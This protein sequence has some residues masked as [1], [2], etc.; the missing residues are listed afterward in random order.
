METTKPTNR[1]TC[2]IQT[3]PDP[4]QLL[5]TSYAEVNGT[6]EVRCET[7]NYPFF[8]VV[9]LRCEPPD[10][11]EC[12]RDAR[13]SGTLNSPVVFHLYKEGRIEFDVLLYHNGDPGKHSPPKSYG[14]YSCIIHPCPACQTVV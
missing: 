13:Y 9:I 10:V 6:L 11:T 3:T 2:A 1:P 7:P 4:D 12:R 8:E 14:P 5:T